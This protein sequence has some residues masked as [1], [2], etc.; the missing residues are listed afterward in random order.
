MMAA[1]AAIKGAARYSKG[2]LYFTGL[3]MKKN[4]AKVLHT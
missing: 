2:D 3:P 1:M 4:R